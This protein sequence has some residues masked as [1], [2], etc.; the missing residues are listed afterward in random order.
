M[1]YERIKHK[2]HKMKMAVETGSCLSQGRG[3][4]PEP[5]G[6]LFTKGRCRCCALVCQ[7]PAKV[8]LCEWETDLTWAS[9]VLSLARQNS[10]KR[11]V[12]G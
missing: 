10:G 3:L 2:V 6:C 5:E 9:F 8:H 11:G 7:V 12:W 4:P 1:L